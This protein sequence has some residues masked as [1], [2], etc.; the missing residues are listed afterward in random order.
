MTRLSRCIFI[1]YSSRDVKAAEE[2]ENTLR[3]EGFEVW[4]DGRNIETDWSAEIA[5]ALTDRAEALCLVWSGPASK[6]KW[7]RNEWLTARAIEKLIIPWVLPG[8][9]SLPLPLMNLQWAPQTDRAGL[10]R[11]FQASPP[12]YDF[13]ILPPQVYIPFNPSPIFEGRK[14]ELSELYR[15]MIGN[16]NKIGINQVGAVGMGGIGKTQ[17]AVEFI[18]RFSFAFDGVFW[19]DAADP[20]KWLPQIVEIARDRL[21]LKLKKKKEIKKKETGDEGMRQYVVALQEYCS[22]NRGM[23]VVLDNVQDP[24]LLNSEGPLF[25]TAVLSLGCNLLFTT[26]S[27]FHLE[28]V[29]EH[30]V[31]ILCA[32]AASALLADMRP[33]VNAAE[34]NAAE[35]ICRAVGNLPLALVLIGSYLRK[36]DKVSYAEYYQGL[37]ERGLPAIEIGKVLPEELATRHQGAIGDVLREQLALVDNQSAFLLFE[38]A[39]HFPENATVPKAR[40]GLLAGLENISVFERPLDEAFLL[41]EQLSLAKPAESGSAIQLHPLVKDFAWRLVVETD[42]RAFLAAAAQRAARA[43]AA[44]TRLEADCRARGIGAVIEDLEV[45]GAW[46]ESGTAESADVMRLA[47]VLDR[48]RHNLALG[49]SLP[50]QVHFRAQE[51]GFRELAD[52]CSQS[53]TAVFFRSLWTSAGEDPALIRT[54]HGHSSM[55][56]AISFSASGHYAIS[57]S[58]DKRLF[59]WDVSTGMR[60]RSFDAH[61]DLVKSVAFAQDGKQILSGSAD[62]TMVLWD[63]DRTEPVHV[64]KHQSAVGTVCFS[65]DGKL[66]VSGSADGT[67]SVWSLETRKRIRAIPAHSESVNSAAFLSPGH[68][69]S[70]SADKTAKLWD[71]DHRIPVHS[72]EAHSG[73]VLAV[74]SD[75]SGRNI[76]SASE[77]CELILWDARKDRPIRHFIGHNAPVSGVAFLIAGDRAVSSSFDNTLILWD[78]ATGKPVRHFRGHSDWVWAV[79]VS[80]DGEYALSACAD[81]TLNVWDLR[82]DA[83]APAPRTDTS[84]VHDCAISPDGELALSASH[85]GSIIV[86]N[87]ATGDA[88]YF[89]AGHIGCATAVA[90]LPDRRRAISGSADK[91]VVLWDLQTRQYIVRS[92]E[93]ENGIEA[94]AVC[95]DGRTALVAIWNE[96]VLWDIETAGPI[97]HFGEHDF[98]I[99]SIALHPDGHIGLSGG[100]GPQLILWDLHAQTPLQ[101]LEGHTGCIEHV[102]FSTNGC[103]ALSASQDGTLILW[104]LAA[105]GRLRKLHT[106][107]GHRTT[108]TSVG[109][110]PDGRYAISGSE[111][112]SLICWDL[113]SGTALCRLY[114]TGA[115]TCLALADR[116]MIYGDES[117]A[118]RCME[119]AV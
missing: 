77:D 70:G 13:R 107:T 2:L 98:G 84:S 104:D 66:A 67:L 88:G 103:Q 3:A 68:V 41:L 59:L 78:V 96:L 75:S 118:V 113:K 22:R 95:Q 46:L 83:E 20:S 102:C 55:V 16:L 35:L 72:F 42:R 61:A 76:L 69:I 27:R 25:G 64:F 106:L 4:R 34:R 31:D 15:Q 23:L 45:A 93:Q 5:T 51:A 44:P 100:G 37:Q 32:D 43:Y 81:E 112:K 10:L 99:R 114:V 28:G 40:L 48:E 65:P 74:A 87:C 108:V 73:S 97:H 47:R 56:E 39:G 105:E 11:I 33:Q 36:M 63:V 26:R 80:P 111:D 86:W 1:S 117:G 9:P 109:F 116:R 7:V 92:E 58:L 18:H 89:S 85:D 90:L 101:H 82:S 19:V 24:R 50:Q 38:L 62:K 53:R 119:L 49:A 6:S 14:Q 71:L 54:L 21:R 29:I 17:L 79:A 115:V 30:E 12:R 94:L 60:I 52:R 91:T 110:A 8:A 57:G